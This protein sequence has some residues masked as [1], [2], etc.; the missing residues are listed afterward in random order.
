MTGSVGV[1]KKTV[2]I[3]DNTNS[4]YSVE[5]EQDVYVVN[6][7]DETLT[8]QTGTE[9][10][11]VDLTGSISIG[12]A[13][14][15]NTTIGANNSGNTTVISSP[16]ITIG[17][18]DSSVSLG[19]LGGADTIIGANNSGNTATVA[20][21]TITIG[22]SSST[23][24]AI[25]IGT[26][27][28]STMVIGAATSNNSTTIAS[29][30]V[31]MTTASNTVKI[32]GNTGRV[33]IGYYEG[34]S[35]YIGNPFNGNTTTIA[36]QQTMLGGGADCSVLIGAKASNNSTSILASTITL[37]DTQGGR[38]IS[39]GSPSVEET[40]P[41]TIYV[42]G[43][44][45]VVNIGRTDSTNPVSELNIDSRNITIGSNQV[46]SGTDNQ[47]SVIDIYGDSITADSKG[48]VSLTASDD[49]SV[50]VG[51]TATI[52]SVYGANSRTV[53]ALTMDKAYTTHGTHTYHHGDIVLAAGAVQMNNLN[54][55]EMYNKTSA[56]LLLAGDYY[57]QS[58]ANAYLESVNSLVLKGNS[59]S[60]KNSDALDFSGS[61][62]DIKSNEINT[63]INTYAGVKSSEIS[64]TSTSIS[65]KVTAFT[66]A[67]VEVTTTAY[68][69]TV[70]TYVN[71][72]NTV[73]VSNAASNDDSYLYSANEINQV[74]KGKI[75]ISSSA[76]ATSAFVET[77]EGTGARSYLILE[78]DSVRLG[79]VN[80]SNVG[81]ARGGYGVPDV[82]VAVGAKLYS[83]SGF[84]SDSGYA[85][86]TGV[87][88]FSI[89]ENED[90]Q[91]GDAV[92]LLNKLAY[93]SSSANSKSCVGIAI[94]VN[95]G[96]V[97]VAAVGD[98]ECGQL[99]GFKV[100]NENGDI[101]AGDLLVTSS[102]PGYLM[103][104]AD[105]IIRS[106]TVGKVALDVEFDQDGLALDIYGFVYC[107]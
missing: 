19:T 101:T 36:S 96:I 61:Y 83:S 31:L 43:K 29:P 86:F 58:T 4:K 28:T 98:T 57:S 53:Y 100:C 10:A 38:T 56:R 7:T 76:T 64:H 68:G 49:F 26:S 12:T 13:S 73:G 37:G 90:I 89:A 69:H 40:A 93:K 81:V 94:S 41:N 88:M 102:R 3:V 60:L 67:N 55:T 104:Q 20:S 25:N 5:T 48:D 75:L 42:G 59:G 32:G 65:S 78:N 35:T 107:G 6:T 17:T 2:K 46:T 103:R 11:G 44:T 15:A 105:D 74:A 24:S 71:E 22:N 82:N 70:T 80:S 106:Y 77:P 34:C 14:S 63:S 95:S 45:S 16:T 54:N 8:L 39:I 9:S 18:T 97:E 99:K 33:E 66:G 79:Y 27:G 50:R 30:T 47:N 92:V 51:D 52:D 1:T 87:H 62:I 72:G 21:P 84:Y 91:V 85:P 23:G